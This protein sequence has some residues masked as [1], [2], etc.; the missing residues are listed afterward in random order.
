LDFFGSTP[1]D[2]GSGDL[3]R[4]PA[5][6]LASLSGFRLPTPPGGVIAGIIQFLEGQ[7]KPPWF[8][9]TVTEIHRIRGCKKREFQSIL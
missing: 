5:E 6:G 8:H 7:V 9:V 1:G 3:R 4:L 2:F